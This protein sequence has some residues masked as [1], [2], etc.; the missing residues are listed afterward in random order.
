MWCRQ[1]LAFKPHNSR[2]HNDVR[3]DDE[4]HAQLAQAVDR[5]EG[6]RV[7]V[8]CGIVW[9]GAAICAN[10]VGSGVMCEMF[11]GMVWGAEFKWSVLRSE[12][13]GCVGWLHADGGSHEKAATEVCQHATSCYQFLP[14]ASTTHLPAHPPGPRPLPCRP[15]CQS[16][17]ASGHDTGLHS[18][19]HSP[20]STQTHTRQVNLIASAWSKITRGKQL[21]SMGKDVLYSRADRMLHGGTGATL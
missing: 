17:P 8:G 14:A 20:C 10:L 19:C 6:G 15:T 3:Q 1:Q 5:L 9:E 12:K 7:G 18:P 16:A 13:E 2:D 11:S 4:P 21:C